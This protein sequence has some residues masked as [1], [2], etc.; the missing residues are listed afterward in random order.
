[1]RPAEQ[2]NSVR[3]HILILLKKK[4]PLSVADLAKE[5]HLT[6]MAVRQHLFRLEYRGLVDHTSRVNKSGRSTFVG[7]PVH[8]Y[9]LTEEGEGGFPRAYE[10]FLFDTFEAIEHNLSPAQIT[11]I[12]KWRSEKVMKQAKVYLS[13]HES[14]HTKLYRLKDFFEH[15]GDLLEIEDGDRDYRLKIFHCG[16][17]RIAAAYNEICSYEQQMLKSL[18]GENVRLEGTL[19][20][21]NAFCTFS[22]PHTVP[23]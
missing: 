18:L 15:N 7:R 6:P 23:G 4:G 8:L 3:K 5:M 10:N 19:V 20:Q 13:A 9:H 14:L 2:E 12:L 1:M 22:V 21:K 17:H 16:I 11:K